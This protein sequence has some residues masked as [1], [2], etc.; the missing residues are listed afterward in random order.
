MGFLVRGTDKGGHVR[1]KEM[2]SL[3]EGVATTWHTDHRE[4]EREFC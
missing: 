2:V 4:R 3:S 1:G